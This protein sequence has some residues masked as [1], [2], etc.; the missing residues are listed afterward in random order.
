MR[1]RRAWIRLN[2]KLESFFGLLQVAGDH[3]MVPSHNE[4]FLRLAGSVAKF[5]SLAGTLNIHTEF[6]HVVKREAHP[7]VSECEVRVE[8]DGLLIKPVSRSISGNH[9]KLKTQA[10]RFQSL[11]RR[12][13]RLFKRSIEFLNRGQRLAQFV[14]NLRSC[15]SQGVEHVTL[16]ARL[17]FRAGQHFAAGAVDR[18]NRQKVRRANLSYR[19]FED[20]CA[21]CSL[22]EFSGDVGGELGIRLLAHHLQGLLDLLIGHNAEKWRLFQLHGQPLPQGAVENRV[23]RGVSEIC[24]DNGVLLSQCWAPVEIEVT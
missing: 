16:V 9:V 5:V 19:A 14:P 11:K 23:A 1:E 15:L 21:A 7:Y 10:E 12:G 4:V 24:E 2:P 8:F 22:A 3:F 18:L 13:S 20:S 6:A 17:G